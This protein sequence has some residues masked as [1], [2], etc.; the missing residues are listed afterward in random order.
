MYEWTDPDSGDVYEIFYNVTQHESEG[1]EHLMWRMKGS[2][3]WL[4]LPPFVNQ[5][6]LGVIEEH[7]HGARP[8]KQTI[9]RV[10][11]SEPRCP[12]CTS[13]AAEFGDDNQ[14]LGCPDCGYDA[15]DM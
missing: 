10:L 15:P 9:I 12:F 11:T 5:D 3:H 1:P 2:E 7:F 8:M 4:K 13:R 6:D 14:L